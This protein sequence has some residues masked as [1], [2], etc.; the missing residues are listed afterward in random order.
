MSSWKKTANPFL[1]A[2]LRL[3]FAFFMHHYRVRLLGRY[4]RYRGGHVA[5]DHG[6]DS[7]PGHCDQDWA[8][9]VHALTR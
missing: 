8:F 2:F 9:M 4:G 6:Q 7:K 3:I 5:K 1:F